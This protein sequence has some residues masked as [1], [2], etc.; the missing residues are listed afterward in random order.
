MVNDGL[1]IRVVATKRDLATFIKLPWKIYKDYPQWVPPLISERKKM[2]DRQHNPFFQHSQAEYFLAERNGEVVGRIAA[3]VNHAHNEFH[4]DQNG[5]F[6]FFEAVEDEEVFRALLTAAQDWLR[7]RGMTGV[8]GPMNPSSNDDMGCLLQGYDQPPAVMMPYNPPYYITLMEKCGMQKAKDLLAY[9]LKS[10]EAQESEKLKAIA[11]EVR[12]KLGVSV[13]PV[14]INDLERELVLIRQVYNDAWSNNWGFVP[15]TEAEFQHTANDLK[16]ILDPEVALLAFIGD[17][18]VAFLV[19]LPDINEI[20]IKI[21]DG[22]LFPTG[23]IKFLLGKNK[24]RT[25]RVITLGVIRD[26][27]QTGM[28]ALMYLEIVQRGKKRGYVK[29]EMSWILE[30]NAAMNRGAQLLGG[31]VSKKYRI[32]Q[33]PL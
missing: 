2:L 3:I 12:A 15:M 25:V 10:A 21:R 4:H 5:F 13:R 19:G 14:R 1:R 17:R 28:G 8:L 7:A 16:Q 29:G 20:L 30:D 22:R 6:G 9:F 33:A 11:A 32:Y 23:F 24:I 18:P 27:Q 26:L 31:S